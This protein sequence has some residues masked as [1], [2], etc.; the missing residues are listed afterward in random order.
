MSPEERVKLFV[1][2]YNNGTITQIWLR[3]EILQ[4]AASVGMEFLIENVPQ[5]HMD[6]TK[7]SVFQGRP[8]FDDLVICQSYCGTESIEQIEERKAKELEEL[9]KGYQ[10][11]WDHYSRVDR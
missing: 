6:S 5:V 3:S 4:L 1:E 7:E 10:L 9:K 2:Y 8:P 11:F